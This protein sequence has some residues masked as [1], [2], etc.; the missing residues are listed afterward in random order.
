M[1]PV[2]SR[3]HAFFLRGHKGLLQDSCLPFPF[4]KVSLFLS[5]KSLQPDG[6]GEETI[7]PP[8]TSADV[9]LTW[10]FP[11]QELV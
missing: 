5:A 1:I 2:P 4:S 10:S 6:Q 3:N 7:P 8:L 11:L 9:R